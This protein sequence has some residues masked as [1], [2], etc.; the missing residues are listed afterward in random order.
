MIVDINDLLGEDEVHLPNNG[1]LSEEEILKVIS[2]TKLNKNQFDNWRQK[3]NKFCIGLLS[4]KKELDYINSIYQKYLFYYLKEF[5]NY[6]Y[7]FIFDTLFYEINNLD[8]MDKELEIKQYYLLNKFSKKL[9]RIIDKI[10]KMN[11]EI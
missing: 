5:F 8:Y 11:G 10:K 1:K 4:N 2:S 3:N 6:E 7:E 9:K